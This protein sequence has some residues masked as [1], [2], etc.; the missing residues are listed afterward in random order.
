MERA[1][2]LARRGTPFADVAATSGYADQA[3]L[4]REIKSLAGAPLSALLT[5]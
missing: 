5:A 1:V 4:S 3:H 2:A